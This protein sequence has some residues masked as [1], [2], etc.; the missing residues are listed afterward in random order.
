MKR[1]HAF[2][3]S[4]FYAARTVSIQELHIHPVLG[5]WMGLLGGGNSQEDLLEFWTTSV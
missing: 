5:F 1:I 4:L 2:F 3:L